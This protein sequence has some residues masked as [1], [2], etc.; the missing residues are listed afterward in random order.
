MTG[1]LG[2]ESASPPVLEAP[3]YI[4]KA[5]DFLST[6]SPAFSTDVKLTD[7]DQCFLTSLPPDKLLGT[8]VDF[9]A[10]EAAVRQAPGPPCDVWALACCTFRLRSGNGPFSG[11]FDVTCPADVLSYI[12]HTLGEA[13]PQ[14]WQ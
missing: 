12:I 1:V 13:T 4:V 14:K 6:S 10:P 9:L 8:P 3:R 5:I 2:T 11:P 7:F